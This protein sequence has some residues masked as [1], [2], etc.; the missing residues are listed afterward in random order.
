M[1]DQAQI[2]MEPIRRSAAALAIRLCLLLF[3]IDTIYALLILGFL[4]I[5]PP[6]NYYPIFIAFLWALHTAKYIFIT[7][8]LLRTVLNWLGT[9]YLISGHHLLTHQGIY[10]VTEKVYELEQLKAVDVHQDWLGRRFHYGTI[11][12]ALSAHG[13]NERIEL[14]DIAEPDKYEQVLAAVF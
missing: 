6:H 12:L 11:T 8:V 10:S 1:N 2:H 14:Y 5:S 4:Y 3:L 7:V 9:S 13:Y